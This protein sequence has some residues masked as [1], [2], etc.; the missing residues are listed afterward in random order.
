MQ[1]TILAAGSRGDIQPYLALGVGLQARGHRVRFAAFRNFASFVTAYGLDF[2]PVDA[3]FQSIMGGEDGQG[4]VA[5]GRNFFQLA[6][7]IRRVVGPILMQI[8]DD[9]WRACGDAEAIIAGLNGVPF[10]GYE[11]AEKLRVRCIN[12]SVLPLSSTSAWPN[13]MWPWRLKLGG[14]Y[15]LLT[16][17]LTALV[18]WQLFGR[19]INTWRH[20]TLNLS[21]ISRRD[22]QAGIAHLPMLY[23][24][25][26]IVL[27]KPSD[28]PNHFH[29]TGYWF[30]PRPI[31]WTP[32]VDLVR[33]LEAGDPPICF[34]FGSMVDR[35]S[36]AITQI[37]T[38]TLRRTGQRGVLVTA[39]GSLR[40]IVSSD[41]VLVIDTVPFDWLLPQCAAVVHHGGAGATSAGLRAGVPTIIVAFFADQP[42]WGR[43][44][45]E[46]GAGPQPI[47]RQRLTVD[48]LSD[49]ITRVM[50]NRSMQQQAAA[51]G[52]R[53]RSEDGIARA[54]EIIQRIMESNLSE[55]GPDVVP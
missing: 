26:P 1:L 52:Q 41:R 48:R 14:A 22:A 35:D 7:S 31:D 30:L 49:A 17:R 33:F 44:V 46:L 28:W 12:A 21:P 34:S 37:V 36:T 19:A 54:V 9:F 6:L 13:P 24:I 3:D 15:N 50:S 5:A 16:H 51:I 39:W 2:A 29:L 38:E 20:T 27:P 18:G 4:M 40:S 55:A 47:M 11:F 42:F 10:F 53:L 25:S 43:R 23:G 45:F 32:P 8:G